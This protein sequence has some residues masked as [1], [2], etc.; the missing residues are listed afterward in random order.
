MQSIG[1]SRRKPLTHSVIASVVS[2]AEMRILALS[3]CQLR[4]LNE[5]IKF[6]AIS[7]SLPMSVVGTL[8]LL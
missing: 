8:W 7:R 4:E 2:G 3:F 5:T 1:I 6:C